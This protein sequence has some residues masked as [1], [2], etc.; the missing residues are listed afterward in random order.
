[1]ASARAMDELLAPVA[2]RP[3]RLMD[4]ILPESEAA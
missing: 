1:M 3:G 2:D 4:V